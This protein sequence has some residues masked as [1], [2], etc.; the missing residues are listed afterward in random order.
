[1]TNAD[2]LARRLLDAQVA[3]MVAR[4]SDD[5]LRRNLEIE[6]DHALTATAQV[7]LNQAVTRQQV[8]DAAHNYAVDLD[9][10][11]AIPGL[12]SDIAGLLYA[13]GIHDR[14]SLNEV[15]SDEQLADLLERM[16]SMKG[17]SD[18][19][20]RQTIGNP[21]FAALASDMLYNGIK[22]YI[23]NNPVTR[24]SRVASS[25]LNFGKS[26]MNLATPG[27]DIL[28][29][30][31]VL[32]FIAANIKA[33]QRQTE[34]FIRARIEDGSVSDSLTRVWND[35]KHASVGQFRELVSGKELEEAI[36]TAYEFWRRLRQTP[37]Y[38]TIIEVVID[39]FFDR[40]GDQTL[41]RLLDDTGIH[42]DMLREDLLRFVPPVV[43]MLRAQDLL[44][45]LV[46]RQLADFYESGTARE[47]LRQG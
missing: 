10:Q 36:L 5:S 12:A 34:S 15:V 42:R 2:S 17:L 46:R 11:G 3:F 25:A 1:M 28:I 39:G 19:V 4:Y 38:W 24:N 30:D 44:E 7:T 6:L 9:W 32:K 13:H 40:Y 31:N 47:I 29:E 8:K 18:K 21:L 43:D 33:T 45:P 35:S 20:V 41:R 23:G 26:L 27:L 37:Y 22:G 14:T 16:L